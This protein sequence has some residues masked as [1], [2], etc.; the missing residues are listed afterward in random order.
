MN[1]LH[2]SNDKCTRRRQ[3]TRQMDS[4]ISLNCATRISRRTCIYAPYRSVWDRDLPT[5][6]RAHNFMR[7]SVILAPDTFQRSKYRFPWYN[8]FDIELYKHSLYATFLF[9][10]S[11]PEYQEDLLIFID[12]YTFIYINDINITKL[13]R[14]YNEMSTCR[15]IATRFIL[16]HVWKKNEKTARSNSSSFQLSYFLAVFFSYEIWFQIWIHCKRDYYYYYSCETDCIRTQWSAC[17]RRDVKTSAIIRSTHCSLF[18]RNC[19]TGWKS[20]L[21]RMHATNPE[22]LFV[23]FCDRSSER[24]SNWRTPTSASFGRGFATSAFQCV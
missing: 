8:Y 24:S 23:C 3:I 6:V 17:C 14:M 13:Y 20:E 4:G 11:V 10:I 5:S 19:S 1:M 9:F 2:E 12:I 16:F 21:H 22:S 7:W 15:K 18:S